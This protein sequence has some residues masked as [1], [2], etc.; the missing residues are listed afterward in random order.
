MIR[1]K[2]I[3]ST[4]NWTLKRAADCSA[5][6]QLVQKQLRKRPGAQEVARV[7]RELSV[8]SS[9]LGILRYVVHEAPS[10]TGLAHAHVRTGNSYLAPARVPETIAD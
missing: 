5:G 10:G 3:L 8:V 1:E 7:F 6:L 4:T 9:K 2:T